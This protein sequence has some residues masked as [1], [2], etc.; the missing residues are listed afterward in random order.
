MLMAAGLASADPILYARPCPST[1]CTLPGWL[2]EYTFTDPTADGSWMTT[3]ALADNH[4][5][6]A[7]FGN[8]TGG[9]GPDPGY[10]DYQTFWPAG[11]DVAQDDL[12]VRTQIDLTGFSLSSV[13]FNLG[14]DNGFKLYLNGVVVA[15]ANEPGYAWRWEYGG[16]LAPFVH[17]GVNYVALALE[18]HGVLTA[19]DMEITGTRV[20]SAP[21]PEPGTLLLIGSGISALALRRRKAR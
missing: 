15:A 20:P 18:D 9:F 16:S 7:P 17:P 5:G 10:F 21:I 13:A 14:V 2:W 8:N 4:M 1:P 3:G 11:G 6:N 19:F 12:W